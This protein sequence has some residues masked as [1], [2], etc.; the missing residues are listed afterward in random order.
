[1]AAAGHGRPRSSARTAR[2]TSPSCPPGPPLGLGGL[3]FESVEL[4]LAEGSLLAL[5]TDGL[6]RAADRDIGRAGSP[7][8]GSACAGARTQALQDD[9][10]EAVVEALLTGPPADDV[11]LLLARTRALDAE[12]VASWE[13]P[14]DPAVVADAREPGRHGS[15]AEWGLDE[16]RSPRS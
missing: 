13:L 9:R 6:H 12:Q 8:A 4:E 11:A 3:P 2:S 7:P 5:Y 10:C 15:C 16:L 1:M 14:T